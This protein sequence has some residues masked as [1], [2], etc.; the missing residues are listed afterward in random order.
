MLY[1]AQQMWSF[2]NTAKQFKPVSCPCQMVEQNSIRSELSDGYV[3]E[4]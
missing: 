1:N 3:V 4:W 2:K